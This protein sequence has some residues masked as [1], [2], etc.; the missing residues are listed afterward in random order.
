M[1]FD[2]W[3]GCSKCKLDQK[4]E[5]F[6]LHEVYG[7]R[8]VYCL[9]CAIEYLTAQLRQKKELEEKLKSNSEPLPPS[10]TLADIKSMCFG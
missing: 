8:K 10:P 4:Y 9:T 2:A 7:A 1:Q 5:S 6:V 3:D